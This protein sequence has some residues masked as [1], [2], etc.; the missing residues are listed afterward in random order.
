MKIWLRWSVKGTQ[1]SHVSW[2]CWS[3]PSQAHESDI[4][5]RMINWRKKFPSTRQKQRTLPTTVRVKTHILLVA[6]KAL[7]AGPSLPFSFIWHIL[8]FALSA[9]SEL[10]HKMISLAK[11]L[12]PYSAWIWPPLPSG[13]NLNITSAR[14]LSLPTR[15]GR[16]AFQITQCSRTSFNACLFCYTD[17]SQRENHIPLVHHCDPCTSK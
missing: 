2:V 7:W 6:H 15:A 10:L 13:L 12:S 16:P 1:W 14:K 8:L 5:V 3:E 17:S 11:M 9:F 4:I